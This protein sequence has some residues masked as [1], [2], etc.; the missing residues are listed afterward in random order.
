MG[1]SAEYAEDLTK[2]SGLGQFMKYCF[3][4]GFAS[5]ADVS[6]FYTMT[7]IL[8]ANHILSNT[9]SFSIGLLVNYF[10]SRE[11]VF[12][13]QTHKFTRDFVLF[14]IIGVIGLCISNLILYLLIDWAILFRLFAWADTGLLKLA[15]KLIAVFTV[16]FWNFAARKRFV[17]HTA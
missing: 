13:Q 3:V 10:L 14:A 2:N 9:L 8:E 11:W 1:K 16:L 17:F 4:G 6:I 15:A 5:L 7:G 12:G